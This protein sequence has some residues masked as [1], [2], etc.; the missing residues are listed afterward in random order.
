MENL[1]N[2]DD[3]YTYKEAMDDVVCRHWQKAMQYEIESMFNNKVWSLV[4]LLKGIKTIGC[5]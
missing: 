3:P 5:K 2:G 1:P 4:D